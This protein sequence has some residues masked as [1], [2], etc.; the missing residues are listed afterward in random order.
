MRLIL[1]RHGETEENARKISMGQGLDGSL[2]SQGIEQAKKLA[3]RLKEESI[4]FAYVSNLTRAVRTAEEVLK[5]HPTVQVI[6]SP[7][8]RER[9]LGIHEGR[10]NNEW[11]EV[12]QQSSLPFHIYQPQE[13]ESYSE[14]QKRVGTFFYTLL[15]KHIDDT[16]L[17]LS[18]TGALTMLLLKLFDKPI[19][20]ENYE[21]F[22]PGNTAVTILEVLP[23]KITT[24]ILNNTDH[25]AFF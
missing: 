1:T 14:L 2:N 15:E 9:N 19:T 11:K 16:V 20:K 24:H 7:E 13:G 23:N 5:F 10:P 4:Q 22:K 3:E 8:L 17:L 12:M 21:K 25:L 18:H 6:L